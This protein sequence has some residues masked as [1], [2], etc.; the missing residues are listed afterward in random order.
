MLNR[1]RKIKEFLK[2]RGKGNI[3]EV[4]N[5]PEKYIELIERYVG[6]NIF[7]SSKIK[8]FFDKKFKLKKTNNELKIS[9]Q[10]FAKRRNWAYDDNISFLDG[11]YNFEK[12]IIR[13]N[14]TKKNFP[15]FIN[16]LGYNNLKDDYEFQQFIQNLTL[17]QFYSLLYTFNMKFRNLD[18]S[19]KN[20]LVRELREVGNWRGASSEVINSIFPVLLSS[21]KKLPNRLEQ[22]TLIYYSIIL[23]HPFENGNGRTARFLY[24]V[25]IGNN[26]DSNLNW[27]FHGIDDKKIY[28]GRF[29]EARN[30]MLVE[31]LEKILL[32]KNTSIITKYIKF[33]PS[34][35]INKSIE[36]NVSDVPI[37]KEIQEQLSI[38]EEYLINHLIGDNTFNHLFEVG[39][40]IMLIMSS[41]KNQLEKWISLNE[42]NNYF[43]FD[44]KK[45]PELFDSWTVEDY[46]KTIL[47]GNDIK[48]QMYLNLIDIFVNSDNY[49]IGDNLLKDLIINYNDKN[50]DKKF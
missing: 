20:Y 30:I 6:N 18:A 2:F 40:I 22:A 7:I 28:D 10:N 49:K 32:K 44:I 31:D 1:E 46:R 38:R 47:I 35:L 29:E 27:Y 14:S 37:K 36:T 21:L 33:F 16:K 43:V 34:E 9:L 19:K 25:I 48:K 4:L 11:L 17:E 12:Q 39:G 41:Y 50:K 45:H 15:R 26:I 5:Y 23:L 24:D 3:E 13:D 8:M 42:D